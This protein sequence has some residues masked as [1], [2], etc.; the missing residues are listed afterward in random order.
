MEDE[1]DNFNAMDKKTFDLFNS[2]GLKE[3]TSYPLF[4]NE[5]DLDNADNEDIAGLRQMIEQE[6]RI[7]LIGI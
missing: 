5:I 4:M 3:L 7:S 6:V 2:L 1:G